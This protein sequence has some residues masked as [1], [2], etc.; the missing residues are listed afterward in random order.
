MYDKV[1]QTFYTHGVKS[2]ESKE[3]RE[4]ET[5]SLS[6][7][8]FKVSSLFIPRHSD[9]GVVQPQKEILQRCQDRRI[10]GSNSM[11]HRPI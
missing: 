10:A 1:E 5:K 2:L 7:K 9:E 3:G 8:L 4:N 11:S 6:D